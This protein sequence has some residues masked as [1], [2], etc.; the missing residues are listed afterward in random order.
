MCISGKVVVGLSVPA[1]KY[2]EY[3]VI[4]FLQREKAYVRN[5]K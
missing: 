3:G 4:S 2:G 5:L 1:V